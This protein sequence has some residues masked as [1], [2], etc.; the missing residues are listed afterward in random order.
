M[1]PKSNFSALIEKKNGAVLRREITY[2]KVHSSYQRYP[3]RFDIA[4]MQLSKR[5]SVASEEL[6]KLSRNKKAYLSCELYSLGRDNSTVTRYSTYLMENNECSIEYEGNDEQLLID[7][8]LICSTVED[9]KA[10]ITTMGSLLVCGKRLVGLLIDVYNCKDKKP[11]IY[12]SISY[13]HTWIESYIQRLDP[14]AL[15]ESSDSSLTKFLMEYLLQ[16]WKRLCQ[17]IVIER[18]LKPSLKRTR[19]PDEK[20][21]EKM[22]K[23]RL[24][25]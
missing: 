20:R 3:R 9:D 7:T 8:T 6:I 10:C 4:L 21:I 11:L 13:F 5:F 23:A 1:H 12:T 17:V 2:M 15:V 14:S 16:N 25:E 24:T 18:P 22:K 19:K